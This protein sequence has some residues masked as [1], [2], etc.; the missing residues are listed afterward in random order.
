MI[1]QTNNQSIEIV[2][3][4]RENFEPKISQVNI[5]QPKIK[6]ILTEKKN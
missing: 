2:Q 1:N 3:K 4:N 6:S 5:P